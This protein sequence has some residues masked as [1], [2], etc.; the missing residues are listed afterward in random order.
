[1]ISVLSYILY[2]LIYIIGWFVLISELLLIYDIFI[3]I[4]N[5]A[6]FGVHRLNRFW[7]LSKNTKQIIV[8]SI[9][10][11]YIQVVYLHKYYL[12]IHYFSLAQFRFHLFIT[13]IERLISHF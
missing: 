10:D 7:C 4:R 3:T 5:F 8:D 6:L 2:L 1:M 12:F 11:A 13:N 9:I